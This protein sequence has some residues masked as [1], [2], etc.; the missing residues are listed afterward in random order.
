MP[1]PPV[2]AEQVLEWGLE[3]QR[4]DAEIGGRPT[5]L[6]PKYRH[7]VKRISILF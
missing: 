6:D 3:R 2:T 4:F 1:P 7:G 5:R